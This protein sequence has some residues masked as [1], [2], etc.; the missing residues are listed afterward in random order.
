VAGTVKIVLMAFM[1]AFLHHS[2]VPRSRVTLADG[3]APEGET[4]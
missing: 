1:A 3:V 2:R 4:L